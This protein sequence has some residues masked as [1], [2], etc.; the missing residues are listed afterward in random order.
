MA[1]RTVTDVAAVRG[2][3][4]AERAAGHTIAFVPTM[5]DLH[6]GHL[7]LVSEARRRAQRVVVSVFVNPLQF[8]PAEDF[9]S[10]PRGLERDA[11]QLAGAGVDL[12]FAPAAAA[13]YPRGLAATTRVEVPDITTILCGAS[14][15]GHFTGVATVVNIL[16]NIVA[17]DV[18]VFGDKD[19]QQLQVIRRMVAD[20]HLPVAIVGVPTERAADG[21]ALS[22]RNRY[23]GPE[24][25]RAAPE[26]HRSLQEAGHALEKGERDFAALEAAAAA[27][28]AAAGFRV[29]YVSIREADTLAAPG[30]V[31]DRFVVLAA[32]WLGQARLIDN[33]QV[34]DT[35]AG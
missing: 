18:A 6:A 34:T 4:A 14:R 19:Y 7:A 32:A 26:L 23:L 30:P 17:P 33:L 5:G 25:R 20:L 28:L 3:V 12:L 10:Y 15:P 22:S 2:W 8:G 1:L 27:R 11:D 29:D 31:T 35:P 16:F 21:L 9:E 13:I 24:E